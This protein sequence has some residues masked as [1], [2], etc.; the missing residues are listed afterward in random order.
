M[1]ATTQ[2]SR[3]SRWWLAGLAAL[4]LAVVTLIAAGAL[5]GTAPAAPDL[6][7]RG[8]ARAVM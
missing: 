1:S 7:G 8:D 3:R 5:R 4:T 2:K 6:A